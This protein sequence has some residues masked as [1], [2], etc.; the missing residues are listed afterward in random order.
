MTIDKESLRPAFER[1]Y[2]ALLSKEEKR[3]VA[4]PKRWPDGRYV[5]DRATVCWD[6]W[7]AAFESLGEPVAWLRDDELR[8]LGRPYSDAPINR[9]SDSMLIHAKGTPEAAAQF[10][11]GVPVYRLPGVRV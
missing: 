11:H 8:R 4:H 9:R 10:G 6:S 7:C 1:W 2:G 5:S 3:L